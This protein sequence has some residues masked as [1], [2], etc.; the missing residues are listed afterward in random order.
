MQP[1]DVGNRVARPHRRLQ[2]TTIIKTLDESPKE[3]MKY[4]FY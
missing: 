2:R 4:Q 1:M 3:Y